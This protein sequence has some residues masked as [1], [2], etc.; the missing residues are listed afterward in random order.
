VATS[1]VGLDR[2]A[3]G[4][5]WRY[6]LAAAVLA[7]LGWRLW[8]G[9]ISRWLL[10]VMAVPATLW[11][12]GAL[13]ASPPVRVPEAPRYLFPTTIAVL[14]VAVEAARGVRLRRRGV[15]ILYGLVV[16]A[17]ASN[18]LLLR[19]GG[20]LLRDQ[21][22]AQ[23]ATLTSLEIG[24]GRMGPRIGHELGGTGNEHTVNTAYLR[25]ER[26]SG[27][28]AYSLAEL[29]AAPEAV[30]ERVD[31]DLA[32]SLRVHLQPTSASPSRCTRIPSDGFRLPVGGATLR[33]TGGPATLSL[34]RFGAAFTVEA[35][36]LD[37]GVPMRLSLPHDS[38]PDSWYGST[39]ARPLSICSGPG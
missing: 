34:R 26:Q 11:I 9:G 19:S 12:I 3:F 14:L 24:G 39:S 27:S 22:I 32:D 36:T 37:P 7:A 16:I 8:R 18:F 15:M 25:A 13:A 17:L 38:A 20:K 31:A 29:R 10:A 2:G 6:A 5:G 21:A 1:L 33:T 28:P 4:T 30:R 23:R 35:G